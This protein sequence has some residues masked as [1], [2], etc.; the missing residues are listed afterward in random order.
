M[1]TN[2]EKAKKVRDFL[3]SEKARYE[4]FGKTPQALQVQSMIRDASDEVLVKLYD[5]VRGL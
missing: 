2:Q 1:K 4:A 3:E 5:F